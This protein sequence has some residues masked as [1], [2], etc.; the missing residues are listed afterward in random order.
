MNQGGITGI[1]PAVAEREAEIPMHMRD[2]Q[3]VAQTLLEEIANL[4]R[5]LEAICHPPTPSRSESPENKRESPATAVG[6]TLE[7]ICDLL[8]QARNN[9]LT[10][11]AR[12]EI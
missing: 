9:V 1:G 10:I 4:S 11:Q 6:N 5:R 2:L 12:L 7:E 8:R 3:E